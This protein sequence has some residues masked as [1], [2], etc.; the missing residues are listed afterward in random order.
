[1]GQNNPYP[2]NK[3]RW[4][5]KQPFRPAPNTLDEGTFP[6]ETWTDMA[7]IREIPTMEG[8]H[9][10]LVQALDQNIRYTLGNAAPSATSGFRLTAGN[11]PIAIPLVAGRTRLRLV[12]E[13]AGATLEWQYGE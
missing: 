9:E 10:V 8:V 3:D 5:T 2:R 11:D 6:H 12:E 4:M 7:A 1:M 13:A